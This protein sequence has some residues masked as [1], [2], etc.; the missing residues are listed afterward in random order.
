MPEVDIAR[1]GV[2]RKFQTPSIFNGLTVYES[3]ELAIPGRQSLPRNFQCGPAGGPGPHPRHFEAGPPRPR[4]RPAR[5]ISE[6]R[7]ATVAGNQH[8]A[9]GRPA[10]APGRRAGRRPHR[11]GNGAHGRAAAGTA[12]R[13]QRDGDRAR[14]GVR[15]A[16][17]RPGHRAQR[18][19]RDGPRH[20]RP[21]AGRSARGRGL[22]GPRRHEATT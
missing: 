17:R 9:L 18:R 8:A 19:Q 22:L 13:A 7:T 4:G 14:H 16:A 12:G 15:A 5:E 21:G 10:S 6:P 2:G 1:L 3:M 11:R 20:A